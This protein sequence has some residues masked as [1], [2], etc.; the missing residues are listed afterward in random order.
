MTI[1]FFLLHI[2]SFNAVVTRPRLQ[3]KMLEA[4]VIPKQETIF[5]NLYIRIPKSPRGWVVSSP[6]LAKLGLMMNVAI[7]PA[8][9]IVH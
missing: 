7:L 2:I 3:L 8:G 4:E 9:K 5:L 1:F 6:H